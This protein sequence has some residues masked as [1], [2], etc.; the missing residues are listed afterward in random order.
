M[1]VAG[2]VNTRCVAKVGLVVSEACTDLLLEAG[3]SPAMTE[4]MAQACLALH[5]QGCVT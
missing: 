1:Q 5:V 2:R 3:L 4:C